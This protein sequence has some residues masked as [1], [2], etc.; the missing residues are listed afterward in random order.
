MDRKDIRLIRN[1]VAR[2]GGNAVPGRQG[3]TATSDGP[4]LCPQC[5]GSGWRNVEASQ[6]RRVTR[7]D[8]F[9]RQL[10]EQI[11]ESANIPERFKH[12][13]FANYEATSA[14]GL[15]TAKL[16][17]ET[18]AAEYPLHQ[19]GLLLIGDSGRGKTHLA[20]AALKELAKK[21]IHCLFCDYR[22]LIKQIQNSYN[23]SSET[24]ELELVRPVFETEVVVFDDLGAQRP[25]D[26]VWDAVNFIL[27]SRYN[28]KLPTIITTNFS[29]G[30]SAKAAGVVGAARVTRDETLGDRIGDRM[31]SRLF[32]M[33]RVV[34]IKGDDYRKKFR[35]VS[36]G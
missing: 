10:G 15:A 24:T 6:E 13:E 11:L 16:I 3:Q 19:T 31:R 1:L 28:A 14:S 9:L 36:L 26:W 8:C 33:C 2:S 34:E 30:L 4:P 35:S 5:G 27:N 21:C 12:C 32:E 18:W 29:D 23:P 22:E 7:C 25:S 20:V 17:V